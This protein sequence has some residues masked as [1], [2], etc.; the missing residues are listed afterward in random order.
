[1]SNPLWLFSYGKPRAPRSRFSCSAYSKREAIVVK[2]NSD[3]FPEIIGNTGFIIIIS[4]KGMVSFNLIMTSFEISFENL[5][6]IKRLSILKDSEMDLF[7]VNNNETSFKRMSL[8]T[9]FRSN[10]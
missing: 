5:M 3:S 4:S 2:S 9:P 8:G 10:S 7:S 1:M 6:F